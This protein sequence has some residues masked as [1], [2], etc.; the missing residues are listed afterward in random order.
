MMKGI[1][2]EV[3]VLRLNRREFLSR[4][5]LLTKVGTEYTHSADLLGSDLTGGGARHARAPQQKPVPPSP[6][7]APPPISAVHGGDSR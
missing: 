6:L 1:W 5:T 7:G 3:W 4:K 2:D